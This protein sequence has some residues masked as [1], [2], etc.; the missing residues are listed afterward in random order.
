MRVLGLLV[1]LVIVAVSAACGSSGSG[2]SQSPTSPTTQTPTNSNPTPSTV[3]WNFGTQWQ[4][5]GT[6]PACA[7][8]LS[9]PAPADLTRA[10]AILY[11]GQIRGGNYKPHGG[12]LF[13]TFT[14]ASVTVTA[15]MAGYVYRGAR[16]IEDAEVQYLFDIINV[17]GVMHRFDHLL[18]LSARFQAIANTFPPATASSMTTFL[19]TREEI[20][21][22]D[23]LATAVGHQTTGNTGFDWGVY[24]L[25]QRNAASADPSWFAAH[26][27][28]LAPYAICWL[29]NLS[30][31]DAA[32]AR[33]LPAGDFL[34]GATSDYCR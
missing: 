1:T 32:R 13:P 17:C 19:S 26:S 11:P 5:S 15:P 12:M 24:D 28:E 9:F 14:N 30:G 2:G 31:A 10:T 4:A 29:D 22:G 21:A 34:M 18:T 8:P 33:A 23:V 20:A 27:G 16:Y 3:T 25:R 6:P 7:S